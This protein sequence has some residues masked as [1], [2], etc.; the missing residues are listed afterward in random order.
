MKR[1]TTLKTLR[2]T[3][4]VLAVC[5][6]IL[7]PCFAKA[8]GAAVVTVSAPASTVAPEAQF[9]VSIQVT[10]NN[11]IAGMQ[12]NLSFDPSLVTVNSITEG[13]LLDQ[14]GANT[15][16]SAGSI[17]NV[18]GTV[19]NV[20]GA[21]ISPGQTVSASGVFATLSMTAKQTGGNCPLN[22]SNVIIGDA[23][24]Q[25]ITVDINNDIVTINLP[26]VLAA[27]GNRTVNEG[28]ALT[29]MVSAT[30][31]NGDLLTYSAQNLPAGASF[32][33]STRVFAW[34]PSYSQA[35][36]YAGVR[37]NVADGNASDYEDISITV[38]NAFR[39]DI[40]G[41]SHV[42]VLDIISIA[43]HWGESGA[44]GW[45]VQDINENGTVNVLDIIVVGQ[46]WTA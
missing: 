15:Y 24:G 17:N 20:F 26:P 37:F 30:D 44:N 45:I 3:A 4:L 35:G 9:T 22:L 21:I 39:V 1:S 34:T 18:A 16:F 36:T 5:L 40:N 25:S 27:I 38:A 19:T 8:A 28:Q 23:E 29:F 2:N 32:N 41:D 10:P 13:N 33:P 43:Q 14:G 46:N 6:A 42:N 7:V 12:F 11:A 31:P